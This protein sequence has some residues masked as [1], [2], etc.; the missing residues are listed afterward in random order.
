SGGRSRARRTPSGCA[1]TPARARRWRGGWWSGVRWSRPGSRSHASPPRARRRASRGGS[2][3]SRGGAPRTPG[4]AR[5]TRPGP[6]RPTPATFTSSQLKLTGE[7]V[8]QSFDYSSVVDAVSEQWPGGFTP[9][10]AVSVDV[11]VYASGSPC[12]ESG[13]VA[14]TVD[15]EACTLVDVTTT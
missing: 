9:G 4:R 2:T 6:A 8:E 1:R 5:G 3:R 14:T 7:G 12:H 15:L 13:G 10:D 11:L